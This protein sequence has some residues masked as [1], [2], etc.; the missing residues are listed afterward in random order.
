M[1][2]KAEP[3]VEALSWGGD[4]VSVSPEDK[5]AGSGTTA[6]GSP[7]EDRSEFDSTWAGATVES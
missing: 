3:V 6:T 7:I 4:L 2:P 1:A 5:P